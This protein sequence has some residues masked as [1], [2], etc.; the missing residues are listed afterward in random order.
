VSTA[1]RDDSVEDRRIS[2]PHQETTTPT[3]KE[4]VQRMD[5][6]PA[7]QETS[8]QLKL[9]TSTDANRTFEVSLYP[10]FQKNKNKK[11]F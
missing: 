6:S 10:V 8:F 2:W 11:L 4:K 3:Q 7:K 9:K 1:L 5:K